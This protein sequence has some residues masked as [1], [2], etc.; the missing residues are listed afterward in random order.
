MKERLTYR[1]TQLDISNIDNQLPDK[2]DC[3][4]KANDIYNTERIKS[5]YDNFLYILEEKKGLF[6]PTD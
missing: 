2:N 6:K 1:N 4:N 5:I 3:H